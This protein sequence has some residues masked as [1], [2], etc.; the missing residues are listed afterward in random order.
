MSTHHL[1]LE[2]SVRSSVIWMGQNAA[3]IRRIPA[4]QSFFSVISMLMAMRTTEQRLEKTPI[5]KL[6]A[7]GGKVLI[8][9]CGISYNTSVHGVGKYLPTSYVLPENP[10]PYTIIL[11][12]KIYDIDFYVII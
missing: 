10:T 8:L 6:H 7:D 3:F 9:G 5:Y 12:E 2:K 11:P 1:V 4:R